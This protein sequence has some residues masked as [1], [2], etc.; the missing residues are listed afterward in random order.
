[1]KPPAVPLDYIR[2]LTP[3]YQMTIPTA[4]RDANDHMNMRYYLHIFDDAGDVLVA[5]FGLTAAY[6]A[7][8]H[9]G[10]FDLEHHLHYLKEVRIG[11]Q[12]TI[13][14]RLVARSAKRIH[15]LLFMVNETQETLA[16]IFECV[17]SFADLTM[18]RTAPYPPAIAAQIDTILLPHQQLTWP[19]PIC[20]VMSA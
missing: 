18:R 11:D 2:Q 12:V 8:H 10:G 7:E 9:S 20:G 15:Y 3:I 6:H 1:M 17:N 5:Q 19:A 4:F 14:P 13:Y 16:S